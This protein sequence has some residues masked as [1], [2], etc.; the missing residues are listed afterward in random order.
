MSSLKHDILAATEYP[1][2][3][4]LRDLLHTTDLAGLTASGLS[5]EEIL[6]AATLWIA[7]DVVR[8][9]LEA[10]AQVTDRVRNK[11]HNA[12]TLEV[13]RLLVPTDL[14]VNRHFSHA[15]GPLTEAIFNKDVECITFLLESGADPSISAICG[16]D[17][18]EL[19]VDNKS[20]LDV[21]KLLFRHGAKVRRKGLL[22]LAAMNGDVE[23]VDF[24][25]ENGGTLDGKFEDLYRTVG[26][27]GSAL[28]FSAE[29]GHLDVV[30]LLLLRGT[31]VG[32]VD[33]KGK[34]VADRAQL[35]RQE[36]A[37]VILDNWPLR[38]GED[39]IYVP[40]R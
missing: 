14:D 22:P 2:D 39:R 24:L 17:A 29:R 10:G 1:Y 30:K 38:S 28:H 40:D 33:S 35:A 19:A 20:P 25:L 7:C 36:Q 26:W 31:E 12:A 21:I 27:T 6:T 13:Y 8:S 15:G 34:P 11:T 23:V 9:C 5:L 37:M 32:L 16:R 18:L 4:K 3:E